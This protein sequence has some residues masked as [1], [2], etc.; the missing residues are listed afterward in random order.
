MNELAEQP[1]CW[2]WRAG[3]GL[4]TLSLAGA[5]VLII[6]LALGWNNPRPTRLPDWQAAALPLR[7]EA[8]PDE[9]M[10]IL[11]PH[12]SSDFTLEIEAIPLSGSDCNSYGLIYRAQ[13]DAHYYAFAVGSD[14]YYAVLRVTG[15]E[16]TELVNWRQFPH[17]HRG[18]QSNRLRVTCAGYACRF[19][20][21]D[22]YA[23]TV[24]DDTWLA[25]NV[26]LWVR[27][28]GDGDAAIRFLNVF[29]VSHAAQRSGASLTPF[30]GRVI[31]GPDTDE[32]RD[33]SHK[34]RQ[35]AAPRRRGV[36]K[37]GAGRFSHRHRLWIG[38]VPV[39]RGRCGSPVR[40]QAAPIG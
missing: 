36:E 27:G 14:G 22:E 13:D 29:V 8:P 20:V 5:L 30:M 28:F 12:H 23:V 31:L 6:A 10:V 11:L 15:D 35:R 16:E 38:G 2:L 34:Q 32:D 1:P 39:G 18:R 4:A 19:Y 3:L 37:R 17:I 24:E 40:S 33:Y 7:L 9:T 21:N 25:G 26:G